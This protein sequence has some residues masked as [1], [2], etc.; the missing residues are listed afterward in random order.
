MLQVAPVSREIIDGWPVEGSGLSVRVVNSVRTA[1]VSTVGE[2]RA[3]SDQDLLALRSLGRISLGH[4][5][6][7]FKLCG[8]IEQG[9]QSFNGIREL[10]PLFLDGPELKVIVARYG[11]EELSDEKGG[12][13]LQEIGDAEHKTRERVRQ[14]QETA[15]QKLCS[16]T[17]T[18]CLEPFYAFFCA[19]LETRGTSAT[20]VDLRTLNREPAASGYNLCGVFRLL[21]ELHPSQITY[22]N[23]F[24]S[25]LN[26][27]TIQ[28]MESQALDLLNRTAQLIPLDQLVEAESMSSLSDRQQKKQ[29]LSCILDHC[30]QA[31]ATLDQRYFSYES[32]T[33]AFLAEIMNGLERPVHYRKN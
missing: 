32:G 30:P 28:T 10:L 2:L 29:L 7:F 24:F 11:L 21:S 15:M 9:K 14:I 5:R 26:E 18:I 1:G 33:P 27:P 20:C 17:A 6:G 3:Q 23:H 19:L 16:R 4:I 13:T 31:A 12:A 22:H 25:T 8:Q